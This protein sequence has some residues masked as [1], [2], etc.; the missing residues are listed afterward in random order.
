MAF[1][2]KWHFQKTAFF[3][4]R[5][6]SK[7]GTF[8]KTAFFKKW[9]FPNISLE[10]YLIIFSL[11]LNFLNLYLDLT[12]I[13]YFT[14]LGGTGACP[15]KKSKEVPP[16]V[17]PSLSKELL[18]AQLPELRAKMEK[19]CKEF[20]VSYKDLVENERKRMVSKIF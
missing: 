10:N 4:K 13:F 9:H 1:S 15:K 6:F 2:K 7:N 16:P 17:D 5:H 20:K 19:T 8:Q 11:R 3:K 14:F 18:H 12:Y